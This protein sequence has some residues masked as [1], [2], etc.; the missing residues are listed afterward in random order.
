MLIQVYPTTMRLAA[1]VLALV[2]GCRKV[3]TANAPP[4][5]R[6]SET[7]RLMGVPWTIT[8]FAANPEAGREAVAAAFA[9]VRRLEGILS[10]Y[11]PQSELAQLSAAAPTQSPVRVGDDLWRVLRAAEGWREMS[12]GAFDPT[13]GPLTT[14]WRQARRSGVM[15]RADK[16][17]AA[18]Q[19]VGAAALTLEVEQQAVSLRVPGMRLDLGGIGMGYAVDRALAVLAERGVTRA[20]VDASGDIAVSGP[21]P[22]VAAWR[23]DVAALSDREGGEERRVVELVNA[24]VT[25]SGDAFQAVEIDCVRYS[26]IVDPRTGLG[27]PGPAAVTVI[28]PD[29]TTADA[30]ATAA[31]VLGPEAGLALVEA[32]PGA[33]ARFVAGGPSGRQEFRSS[34][35]SSQSSQPR[36]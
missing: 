25:T 24:A 7:C 28:A 11:D 35:W 10:D 9:E 27:V 6:V 19:A 31:S 3:G 20:M 18:R 36:R 13:V 15:P 2:G 17:A 23:I 29:C 16:L 32:V 30:V 34:R 12:G 5:A 21:P 1:C 22:G 33:A 14:L 26:H 8:A 4:A